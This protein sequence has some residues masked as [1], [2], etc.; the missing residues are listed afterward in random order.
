MEIAR[1]NTSPD[2]RIDLLLEEMDDLKKSV[3]S[4]AERFH[5][6]RIRKVVYMASWSVVESMR[7][8]P[9]A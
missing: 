3:R 5:R 4:L 1:R 2:R 8:W 7:T 9:I 6:S